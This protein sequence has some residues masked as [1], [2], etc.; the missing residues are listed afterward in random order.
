MID[1]DEDDTMADMSILLVDHVR[2]A[3]ESDDVVDPRF[4]LFKIPIEKAKLLTKIYKFRRS[5][6]F[7]SV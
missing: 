7:F 6:S 4:L 5:S 3:L 2:N 1:D